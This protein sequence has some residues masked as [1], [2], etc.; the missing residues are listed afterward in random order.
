MITICS[1]GAPR[2]HLPRQGLP[3][4][5]IVSVGSVFPIMDLSTSTLLGHWFAQARLCSGRVRAMATTGLAPGG[6]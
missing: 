1:P 3:G 4:T 2:I 5:A 6:S